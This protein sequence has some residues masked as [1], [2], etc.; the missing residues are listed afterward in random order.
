M[1][2]GS[3]KNSCKKCCITNNLNDTGAGG[4]IVFGKLPDDFWMAK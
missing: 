4:G 1:T 3:F 2:I